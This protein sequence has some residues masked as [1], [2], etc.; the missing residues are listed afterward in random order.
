[1]V[2]HDACCEKSEHLHKDPVCG[3]TVDPHTAKGGSSLYDG[4][5]YYFCNP[6]CKIKFDATPL[7][8]LQPTNALPMLLEDVEYT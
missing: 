2:Q 6:K 5:T 7:T 8:Y 3:M 4:A 1:M